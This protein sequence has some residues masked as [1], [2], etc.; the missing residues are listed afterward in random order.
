M[1]TQPG[2]RLLRKLA[3]LY[4]VQTAYYDVN[5]QRQTASAES[6]LAVLQAMDAPI[7]TFADVPAAI[8]A[9]VQKHWSTPLDPV[10]VAWEGH[11]PSVELRLPGHLEDVRLSGDLLLEDG[12]REPLQWPVS[13]LRTLATTSAGG[14]RY[15][16]KELPLQGGLPY[17]YHHLTI[18]V[19]GGSAD[20]LILSA[21]IK[22]Y[23]PVRSS[24]RKSWGIFLPL[25]ALH[26]EHNWGSGTFSDLE[27]L[28][29]WVA[30]MGGEVVATLPLL[31]VFLDEPFEPSPYSPVSRLM[32]NAFYVDAGRAPEGQRAKAVQAMLASSDVS[33]EIAALKSMSLVDYKRH[34]KLKRRLLEA[35]L[36][37]PLEQSAG[38]AR[39]IDRFVVDHPRV[40]DYALFMAAC[41]KQR[42]VW[43]QWPEPMRSGTLRAGDYD[44]SARHYHLYAQWLSHQ[45]MDA[46]ASKANERGAGL[47]LDLPLGVHPDGYD[48]WRHQDLF[49]HDTRVGSPPDAFFTRG[50]DWGFPPFHPQRMR[51]QHY[52]Y[53]IEVIR[54]HLQH[55][56]MLRLDHV[57]GLHR[58]YCIPPGHDARY[59]AYLRYPAEEL[60][61]I[62]SLESHR[63]QCWIIGENLGT[64]PTYVNAAMSR[65]GLGKMYVAQFEMTPDPARALNPVPAN[66]VVSF[67]THD[68]PMFATFWSGMD[69]ENRRD[70]GL[71]DDAA[72]AE[73]KAELEA[74]KL[75]L[76]AFLRH[77]GFLKGPASAPAVHAACMAYL[78]TRSANLVLINLE[79]LWQETQPQN[80]PSTGQERPNWCRKTAYTFEAFSQKPEV[81]E[82]L[83]EID[84]RR[85]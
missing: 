15:I 85:Q 36:S 26:H 68:M 70:M 84:K 78:S 83:R 41:E 72:A 53:L 56:S 81:V 40:A 73:E 18:D 57:M 16:A 34:A 30:A 19:P 23:T 48:A 44:E 4:G 42:A 6:L 17:G 59:G 69:I 74:R 3:G 24:A 14:H 9:S 67:N 20:A 64:V 8:E 80:V 47:Y 32:W 49:M 55:A 5:S 79:D 63:E 21:P 10:L 25:Y 35:W 2:I 39:E 77:K 50:Q 45:Q 62:L 27:G 66:A 13:S 58:L 60:Y 61:A 37:T 22:S 76:I 28:I 52:G 43:S 7:E 51:E 54:H 31:A 12:A 11:L 1:K 82:V 33:A 65:H 38:R 29:D 75:A 46:L 71:V